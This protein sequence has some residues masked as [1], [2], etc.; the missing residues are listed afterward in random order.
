MTGIRPLLSET[1]A[2]MP[3]PVQ[4]G[5]GASTLNPDSEGDAA[6]LG[7]IGDLLSQPTDRRRAALA[8]GLV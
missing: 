6:R 5:E 3:K 4:H 2:S 8:N 7:A 1:V